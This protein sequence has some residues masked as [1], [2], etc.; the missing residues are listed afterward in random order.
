MSA[1]LRFALER[2]ASW[3]ASKLG[4]I[5]PDWHVFPRSSRT[6]PTHPTRPAISLKGAWESVRTTAKV[7]CRLHDVRHSFCTKMGEAGA[8]ESTMLDIMGHVSAAM[9]KRYSHIRAQARRDAISSLEK[10]AASVGASKEST[11]VEVFAAPKMSVT[12]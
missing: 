1:A 9:L 12:H 8:P 4:P 7:S 10:R 6:K 3:C 5:H 2:H 11:R